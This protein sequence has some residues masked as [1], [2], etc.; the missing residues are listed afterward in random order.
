[1]DQNLELQRN[2]NQFITILDT[3]HSTFRTFDLIQNVSIYCNCL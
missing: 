2:Q 3:K 1:M